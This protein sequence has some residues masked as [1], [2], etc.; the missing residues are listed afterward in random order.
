MS[1]KRLTKRGRC[2]RT[3][4]FLSM[5][6]IRRM[7]TIMTRVCLSYL[8]VIN[9]FICRLSA[10]IFLKSRRSFSSDRFWTPAN[11]SRWWFFRPRETS[12]RHAFT[13]KQHQPTRAYR[14]VRI[15][16]P[17]LWVTVLFNIQFRAPCLVCVQIVART[18][19]VAR[20]IIYVPVVLFVICL[21]LIYGYKCCSYLVL[22]TAFTKHFLNA[23]GIT[24]QW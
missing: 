22:L 9:E 2:V 14:Q 16:C 24:N 19:K 17:G 21:R 8:R 18:V 10:Y 12:A 23:C 5:R 11:K 20:T 6:P 7:F 13:L 4:R 1:R 15:H 3:L